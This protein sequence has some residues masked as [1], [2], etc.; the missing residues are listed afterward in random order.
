VVNKLRFKI[1]IFSIFF[2]KSFWMILWP[3]FVEKV[4][5]YF[6]LIRVLGFRFCMI[7][8]SISGV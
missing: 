2:L 7:C 1:S 4:F 3:Q 8:F 5:A 6:S